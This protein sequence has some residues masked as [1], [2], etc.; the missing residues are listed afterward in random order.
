MSAAIDSGP[1][2]RPAWLTRLVQVDTAIAKVE[3][4]VVVVSLLSMLTFYFLYVVF[5][6]VSASLGAN[7]LSE[8]PLQ[9]VLWVSLFGGSIAARNGRHIGIDIAPRVLPKKALRF[10]RVVT[11][12]FAVTMAVILSVAGWRYLFGVELVDENMMRYIEVTL[13]GTQIVAIPTW[14]F[15]AAVPVAFALCAWHFLVLTIREAFGDSPIAT[16][17]DAE[18]TPPDGGPAGEE[19]TS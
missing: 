19:A 4:V 15:V 6:N 11:N 7:W 13:G 12:L 14:F 10:V 2:E 1:D 5:R 17:E 16:D 18:E 8:L 3:G 9:L